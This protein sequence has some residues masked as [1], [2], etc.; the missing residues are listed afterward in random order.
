MTLY[1]IGLG[2]WDEKDITLKG[3]EA[4][5]MA[6]RVYLETYTSRLSVTIADLEKLYGK[7]IIPADR[8]MTECRT[9][10]ILADADKKDIAF[11]V[12]GD[13]FGATTCVRDWRYRLYLM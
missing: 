8:E 11:L 6:D 10:D 9:D 1:I 12:I 7:K 4:V 3:L 5:K 2:L 13:P